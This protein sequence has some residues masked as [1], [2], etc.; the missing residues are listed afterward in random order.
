M[1][2]ARAAIGGQICVIRRITKWLDAHPRFRISIPTYL[3]WLNKLNGGLGYTSIRSSAGPRLLLGHLRV[4]G[5]VL[6]RHT[7]YDAD[8]TRTVLET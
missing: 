6:S 1:K 3:S 5:R 4:K 8:L 2:L 7:G